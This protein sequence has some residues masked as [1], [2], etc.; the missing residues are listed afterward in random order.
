MQFSFACSLN[1]VFRLLVNM[2]QKLYRFKFNLE[3]QKNKLHVFS[4]GINVGSIACLLVP[5]TGKHK[6]DLELL[7]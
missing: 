5:H 3:A 1:N 2:T 6:N 7:E 4:Q